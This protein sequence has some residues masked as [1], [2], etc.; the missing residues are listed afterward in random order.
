[1]VRLTEVLSYLGAK[2]ARN[3]RGCTAFQSGSILPLTGSMWHWGGRAGSD[4]NNIIN[5]MSEVLN[6]PLRDTYGIPS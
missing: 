3:A 2:E 6:D 4:R 5:I 1:M